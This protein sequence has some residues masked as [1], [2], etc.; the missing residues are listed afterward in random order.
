MCEIINE[1]DSNMEESNEAAKC[2]VSC[3]K[4]ANAL[5]GHTK[6]TKTGLKII[7][8]VITLADKYQKMAP[9]SDPEFFR[10]T[11]DYYNRKMK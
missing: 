3:L 9:E 10:N 11:M 7:Q 8:K 5:L 6:P 4:I 1:Y 2:Y